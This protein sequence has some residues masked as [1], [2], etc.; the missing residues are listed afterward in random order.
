MSDDVEFQWYAAGIG[1]ILDQFADGLVL[2][3][4]QIKPISQSILAPHRET[5]AA[6]ES[7][8][9][10]D[11][12]ANGTKPAVFVA[13]ASGDGFFIHE[14]TVDTPAIPFFSQALARVRRKIAD[15][16]RDAGRVGGLKTRTRKTK[17]GGLGARTKAF[18]NL[19]KIFADF[20]TRRE[21]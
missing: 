3:A 19:N 15:N 16:I 17:L 2:T 11:R 9:V 4:E 13:T 7:I 21:P 8:H 12:Y 6:S 5:G 14:G 18:T 1:E 20:A 10:V